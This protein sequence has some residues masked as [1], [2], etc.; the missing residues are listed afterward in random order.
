MGTISLQKVFS[1]QAISRILCV[2]V[3]FAVA[4]LVCAC[5]SPSGTSIP[6]SPESV[7]TAPN[8]KSTPSAV[9]S[10][11]GTGG[12][13][14]SGGNLIRSTPEE[15]QLAID[16]LLIRL[17]LVLYRMQYRIP[18]EELII[19]GS[20]G[21]DFQST[22]PIY[23]RTRFSSWADSLSR[24]QLEGKERSNK[25]FHEDD[26]RR[27]L[28]VFVGMYS[29][30][31]YH[32]K[33]IFELLDQG[34]IR[35]NVKESGPCHSTEGPRDGASHTNGQIC[36]S[37]ERL[38][39][40]SREALPAETVA[41]AIHELAHVF[42][43]G[44]IEAT[45]VQK[46]IL[47]EV[48]RGNLLL[49]PKTKW[50][51]LRVANDL[52]Y[53]QMRYQIARIELKKSA[54]LSNEAAIKILEKEGGYQYPHR[55]GEK[56]NSQR[57]T[58]QE[59]KEFSALVLSTIGRAGGFTDRMDF[60]LEE[61]TRSLGS[62]TN[63]I[64][65]ALSFEQLPD[66]RFDSH[67]EQ[68]LSSLL[69]YSLVTNLLGEPRDDAHELDAD[70]VSPRL[71]RARIIMNCLPRLLTQYVLGRE[72]SSYACVNERIEIELSRLEKTREMISLEKLNQDVDLIT[73]KTLK[74]IEEFYINPS[75]VLFENHMVRI[76]FE[77]MEIQFPI[78]LAR[79]EN[80]KN[81]WESIE[82]NQPISI[83]EGD[84]RRSGLR[85]ASDIRFLAAPL[86]PRAVFL[87]HETNIF[88]TAMVKKW[89]LFSNPTL[90][91]SSSHDFSIKVLSMPPSRKPEV[92][93]RGSDD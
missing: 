88:Q 34:F 35:I 83:F 64:E 84:E 75:K 16:Q 9:S 51:W 63:F 18:N 22:I 38:L 12:V 70:S 59:K 17:R 3:L 82:F 55:D 89:D 1:A 32:Q 60:H 20:S 54:E 25:L 19:P 72:L 11:P 6:S 81:V 86:I 66:D 43:F 93:D 73:N 80:N 28:D 67:A 8:V 14:G 71:A 47:H 42:N 26:L 36:L 21:I 24:I 37:K 10:T 68:N 69:P 53:H 4:I 46:I 7:A 15:V 62:F 50:Q 92:E 40:L 56:V 39:R 5:G 13:D 58:E 76:P 29:R 27:A 77:R 2:P 57:R 31:N 61:M 41:L 87:K 78:E 30:E 23:T 85:L 90:E 44:E 49:D 91:R 79:Y 48:Q 65:P 45:T 33:T 52:E 74:T